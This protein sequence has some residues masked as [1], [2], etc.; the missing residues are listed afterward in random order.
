MLHYV[1]IIG[2]FSYILWR[3]LQDHGPRFYE[4]IQKEPT[5]EIK[6]EIKFTAL[7]TLILVFVGFALFD[8]LF[9]IF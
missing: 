8:L 5:S 1:I 4:Q 6:L 9:F 2:I 7:A 3:T